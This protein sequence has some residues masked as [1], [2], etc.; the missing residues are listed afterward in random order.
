MNTYIVYFTNGNK[1]A[2]EARNEPLARLAAEIRAI[3][4]HT[5]I[6]IV[7][8][9]EGAI[10]KSIIC[11]FRTIWYTIT[12]TAWPFSPY[13]SGHEYVEQDDRS[14]KCKICGKISE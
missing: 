10:M 8:K 12:L 14:L 3:D 9:L 5:T 7:E 4:S 6:D 13:M 11:L 2:V 1:V